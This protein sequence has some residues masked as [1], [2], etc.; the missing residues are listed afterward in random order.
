M[1]TSNPK[2]GGRFRR[3]VRKYRLDDAAVQQ[4]RENALIVCGW[5]ASLMQ[6]TAVPEPTVAFEWLYETVKRHQ[7][8]LVIIDPKSQFFGLDENSNDMT[9]RWY[10]AIGGLTKAAPL[11]CPRSDAR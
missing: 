10:A 9:A 4:F 8:R 7:P 6:N 2:S 5:R 3:V 1:K 11:H